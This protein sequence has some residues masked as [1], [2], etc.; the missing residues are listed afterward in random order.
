MKNTLKILGIIALA[1]LIGFTVVG[2][3][4]EAKSSAPTAPTAPV[5]VADSPAAASFLIEFEA[6]INDAADVM[7]KM[8]S[9]DAS[10]AAQAGALG[11]KA[12]EMVKRWEG[13]SESELSPAQKKKF[14]ELEEKLTRALGL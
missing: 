10:V 1:A 5:V 8:L 4:K 7:Q 11:T 3:K 2:C 12:E 13:L 9:G 14:E 6:F